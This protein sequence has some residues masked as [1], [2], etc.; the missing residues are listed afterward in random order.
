MSLPFSF[1]LFDV[2]E[3]P[4][5]RGTTTEPLP[6]VTMARERPGCSMPVSTDNCTSGTKNLCVPSPLPCHS[7]E[8]SEEV[9]YSPNFNT[10][11]H[12]LNL[13]L[14]WAFNSPWDTGATVLPSQ[15]ASGHEETILSAG[16]LACGHVLSSSSSSV[17][18]SVSCEA[19]WEG[20]LSCS[21][22]VPV[23]VLE[24]DMVARLRR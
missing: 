19:C 17:R 23:P 18:L 24:R 14:L 8:G 1:L 22:T 7:S 13:M 16:G 4:N 5:Y 21:H 9:F 6:T 15:T 3:D 11:Y 10:M 2:F 12:L 20:S